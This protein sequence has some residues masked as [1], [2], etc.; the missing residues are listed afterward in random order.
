M[1]KKIEKISA[2]I[3]YYYLNTCKTNLNNQTEKTLKINGGLDTKGTN[4]ILSLSKEK[5]KYFKM[6]L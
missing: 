6:K 3:I 1:K 4:K 5:K 2:C